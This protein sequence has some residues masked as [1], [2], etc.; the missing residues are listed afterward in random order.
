MLLHPTAKTTEVHGTLFVVA[1]IVDKHVP[2]FSIYL[3]ESKL[4]NY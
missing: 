4:V 2:Y 1:L 3:T